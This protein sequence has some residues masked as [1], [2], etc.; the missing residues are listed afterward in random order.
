MSGVI[1]T[2]YPAQV[3]AVNTASVSPNSRPEK[4]PEPEAT[5]PTPTSETTVAIQKPRPIRSS[6]TT[7]ARTPMKIGVAAEEERD[8]RRRGLVDRV[9]EADLV[10]EDEER[11]EQHE[12]MSRSAMRKLRSRA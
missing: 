4:P 6:P 11:S 1:S 3:A 12:R 5:N 2:E 7:L 10:A 9:D 8:G